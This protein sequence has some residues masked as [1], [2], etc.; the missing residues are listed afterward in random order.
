[1]SQDVAASEY[2]LTAQQIPTPYVDRKKLLH[3]L[4]NRY[5]E[6]NFKVQLR[7]NK[8]TIFVPAQELM[9][10]VSTP[11]LPQRAYAAYK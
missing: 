10:E 11:Y 6:K 3:Q 9:S 5:G 2:N 7:L 1:M 4:Q 8:W